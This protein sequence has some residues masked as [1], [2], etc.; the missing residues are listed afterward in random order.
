MVGAKK[1]LFPFVMMS[2]FQ[3][4]QKVPFPP[5]HEEID[6]EVFWR[7]KGGQEAISHL[8]TFSLLSVHLGTFK[9]RAF[10]SQALILNFKSCN[11]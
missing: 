3:E 9:P 6:R 8:F 5:I 4:K 10:S 11:S 2:D 7:Q 1:S